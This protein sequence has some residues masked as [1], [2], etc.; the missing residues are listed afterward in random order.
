MPTTTAARRI[1]FAT[2][3]AVGLAI[4]VPAGGWISEAHADPEIVNTIDIADI[5]NIDALPTC[6]EEDCSDQPGQIGLWLDRDTGNWWLSVGE[7]SALIIDHTAPAQR[8][9]F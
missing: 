3:L 4:G 1:A 7:S 8:S 5:P 2:G 6:A 9:L